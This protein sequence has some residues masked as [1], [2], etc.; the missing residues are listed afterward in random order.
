MKIHENREELKNDS[1]SLL[2][3]AHKMLAAPKGEIRINGLS[4]DDLVWAADFDEMRKRV[5]ALGAEWETLKDSQDVKAVADF[6]RRA[7]A[8]T[9]EA[10]R[11]TFEAKR[12]LGRVLNELKE[13][14]PTKQDAEGALN[15]CRAMDD[16]IKDGLTSQDIIQAG[17]EDYHVE[18]F[19]EYKSSGMSCKMA[20]DTLR[21]VQ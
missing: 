19:E 12:N 3:D 18:F 14:F 10:T 13:H 16:C 5:A 15:L 7:H 11:F 8:A 1:V 6:C 4:L 2:T 17:G 9:V 20:A 21:L